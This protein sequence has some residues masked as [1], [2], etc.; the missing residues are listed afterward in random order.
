MLPP[1]ERV[2]NGGRMRDRGGASLGRIVGIF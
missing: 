1:R 2:T